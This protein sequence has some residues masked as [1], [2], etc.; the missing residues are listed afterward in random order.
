MD[1]RKVKKLFEML[2]ET[3]MAEVELHEG[4]NSIKISGKKWVAPLMEVGKPSIPVDLK[5]EDEVNE[6]EITSPMVGT[7]YSIRDNSDDNIIAVGD[8]VEVGDVVCIIE[9]MHMKTQ[10]T[11]T[12]SGVVKKI[13]CNDGQA[14]EYGQPLFRLG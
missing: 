2:E 4:A 13:L 3:G 1:I 10:I 9:A 5:V 11:A 12:M 6:R 14:A 8:K 7:F